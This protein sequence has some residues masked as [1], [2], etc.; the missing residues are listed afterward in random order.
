M[1]VLLLQVVQQQS[2]VLIVPGQV[3]PVPAE[4]VRD[5]GVAQGPQV[6]GDDQVIVPGAGFRLPEQGRQGVIGG[7]GHGSPHVVHVG[8]A[9]VHD[10]PAGHMGDIRP[11]PLVPQDAAPGG[12]GGPL[13][14]GSPLAAVGHRHAV[15]PLGS[16]VVGA[17]HAGRR[18]GVTAG[19]QQAPQGQALPH[20]GAGP[21]QAEKR[22]LKVPQSE[23]GADALVQQVPGQDVVQFRR[24]QPALFQGPGQGLLLHGGL[25]LLPGV[26]SEEGIRAQQVKMPRQGAVGLEFSA[27]VGVGHHAGGPQQGHRLPAQAFGRHKITSCP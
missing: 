1:H 14:R 10:L 4:Q 9:H 16:A 13:G 23:G 20:G 2:A 25:R 3:H 12:G 8:D 7:G 6:P 21:V 26:L 18:P 11:V 17:G 27:D 19:E 15:L 22:N 24:G 5:D